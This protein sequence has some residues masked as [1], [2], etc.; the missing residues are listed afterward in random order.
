M[1]VDLSGNYI[2]T[3]PYNF[4]ELRN[5]RILYL[6]FNLLKSD[7]FLGG[8]RHSQISYLT[9]FNNPIASRNGIRGRIA[10][11][12]PSLWALDFH[13]FSEEEKHENVFLLENS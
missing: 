2:E 5:L 11:S 12:I 9:L 8:F 13:A 7:Q 3:L 6:H 4:G 1:K 10:R